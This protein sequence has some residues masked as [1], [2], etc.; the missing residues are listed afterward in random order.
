MPF[1]SPPPRHST[2]SWVG[3]PNFE[4]DPSECRCEGRRN[5][6]HSRRRRDVSN[7]DWNAEQQ[8]AAPGNRVFNSKTRHDWPNELDLQS[9]TVFGS[10]PVEASFRGGHPFSLP[11]PGHSSIA[12]QVGD[13]VEAAYRPGKAEA[14]APGNPGDAKIAREV[15]R[16]VG[17]HECAAPQL[18]KRVDAAR[19]NGTSRA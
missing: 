3:C 15:E 7:R 8:P 17:H 6:R 14:T 19:P 11:W 16:A 9:D 12:G 2:V 18:R 5:E 10:N 1:F 13:G 4:D